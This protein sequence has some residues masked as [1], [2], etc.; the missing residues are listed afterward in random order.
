MNYK[1]LKSLYYK[2]KEEYLKEYER[3]FESISTIKLKIKN[4]KGSPFFIVLTP[5]IVSLIEEI[6]TAFMGLN[7]LV[8]S[9][10]M[11]AVT[12]LHRTCIIDE[13]LLTNNIEGVNSTR[14]EITEAL[15]NTSDKAKRFNGL[16]RKY[17]LLLENE[18][19]DIP[20]SDSHDLRAIYDELVLPDIEKEDK[21]PDGIIFRKESVS[22]M[23]PTQKEKHT[24]ILP[25]RKIIDYIDESL[26]MLNDSGIPS[27][28]KISVLHYLIGYIHPFYDGNGRT[29]R[30]LSS[31]LLTK[32]FDTLVAYRLSYAIKNSKGHYYKAFEIA[33]DE[34]N[35]GD[36]TPF[37]IMFLDAIYDAGCSLFAKVRDQKMELNY[38]YNMISQ[39]DH[40]FEG[41]YCEL[42]TQILFI[43]IQNTLFDDNLLNIDDILSIVN[44]EIPAIG[45]STIRKILAEMVNSKV[46]V[47][48][49]RDGHQYV[50]SLDLEALS[51][52]LENN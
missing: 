39:D 25:E 26:D 24:G 50:Y 22:V 15:D 7:E 43:L 5:E 37:V 49:K 6:M 1:V 48:R 12:S 9:L 32:Y 4:K 31:Y 30:F 38:Y 27:L 46:P 18:G 51:K 45:K 33:N 41:K 42:K 19:K 10:P 44:Q 3:R 34:K 35:L 40:I 20:L 47:N 17:K 16:V 14:K 52:F 8:N 36:L 29:A 23:S 11:V 2:D 28:I 13:I 21:K